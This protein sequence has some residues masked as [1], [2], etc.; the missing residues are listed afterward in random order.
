MHCL[1]ACPG[2]SPELSLTVCP[3]GAVAPTLRPIHTRQ[4]TLL[5]ELL[6]EAGPEDVHQLPDSTEAAE[7][8]S[9]TWILRT[10]EVLRMRSTVRT[11]RGYVTCVMC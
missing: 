9:G 1:C 7:P 2:S 4:A 8:G 5:Q 10:H 11:M 3:S 6:S